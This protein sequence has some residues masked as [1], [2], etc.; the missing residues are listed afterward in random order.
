MTALK[1]TIIKTLK[2]ID[3]LIT[4]FVTALLTFGYNKW[5]LI[6]TCIK[7]LIDVN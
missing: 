6:F 1:T 7:M 2:M 3:L 4:V 5:Q